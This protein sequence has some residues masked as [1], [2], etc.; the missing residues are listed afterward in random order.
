MGSEGD[1]KR[2]IKKPRFLCLHGF[3]TSAEI[4]KKQ[5]HKWPQS[6]INELDLVFLDA[7]FPCQGKSDVEGIF[8]PPY[9]EWFQFNKEFTEY[10][11]F[12][13]CL[14]YIEDYMIKQGP[15]DGLLGFSQGAILSAALPNLQDKGVALTKVPK[16]KFLIIIGGAKFRSPWVAEKAY[17]SPIRCPSL[18]FLEMS[19]NNDSMKAFKK[20][21]K[22]AAAQNISVKA[23]QE[24]SSQTTM[25]LP[26]PGSPGQRR[27]IPTPRVRLVDPPQ[28]ST[29]ASSAPS[30]KKQKINEPFNLDA[31]DFDAVE[32]VDQQVAPYGTLSTD[33]VSLLQ[34]LDFIT[35]NS[36][37]MAH[38][39]AA[40][41]RTV[42]GIPIHATKSF[43]EEAKSEFDR[44]KGLKEELEVKLAKVEK[45][46]EGEKA[47][48]IALAASLKLAE[49]M[50]LKHKDS[51][52]SAYRELVHL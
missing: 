39:G 10:T 16:V 12:D 48:S 3:R 43:M 15:F 20:A 19:K 1:E 36:V 30:S 21:K 4:L 41:F 37:K 24:G 45:E 22:A 13:E 5:V 9:Y 46:L 34:H 14:Q 49:D 27:V 7:P 17:S 40:I 52:V 51:Y 29:A 44:I 31:P 47:S 42:Q 33:D 38:M 11:N 6:V 35:R 8:D 23:A 28:T 32:F 25:K 26:V 2:I 50:A 18:H